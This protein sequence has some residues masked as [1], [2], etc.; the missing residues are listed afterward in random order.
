MCGKFHKY[1]LHKHGVGYSNEI[2]AEAILKGNGI[3]AGLVELTPS[4]VRARPKG[5]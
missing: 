3:A 4:G 5:R 1:Y 2:V